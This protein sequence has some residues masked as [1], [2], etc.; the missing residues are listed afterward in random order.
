MQATAPSSSST[1]VSPISGPPVEK[2]AVTL[3]D[4][5]RGGAEHDRRS[6]QAYLHTLAAREKEKRKRKRMERKQKRSSSSSS[7]KKRRTESGAPTSELNG[8]GTDSGNGAAGDLSNSS[9]PSGSIDMTSLMRGSV[10]LSAVRMGSTGY[11]DMRG[12]I[13]MSAMSG[14]GMGGYAADHGHW[15][16]RSV[17]FG[18]LHSSAAAFDAM[19]ASLDMSAMGPGMGAHF[20]HHGSFANGRSMSISHSHHGSFVHHPMRAGSRH[21]SV[22]F[23]ADISPTS[24]FS[25]E[26]PVF[27]EPAPLASFSSVDETHQPSPP[28]QAAAAP[29]MGGQPTV[30]L[31]QAS[32]GLPHHHLPQ[33]QAVQHQPELTEMPEFDDFVS[34]AFLQAFPDD[35]ATAAPFTPSAL[36]LEPGV[37]EPTQQQP[38]PQHHQFAVPAPRSSV[39]PAHQPTFAPSSTSS[40]ASSSPS[41]HPPQPNCSCPDC[42]TASTVSSS[43]TTALLSPPSSANYDFIACASE[44]APP[45]SQLVQASLNQSFAV[46][47]DHQVENFLANFIEWSEQCAS[48]PI[49][50]MPSP[51]SSLYF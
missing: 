28:H 27:L 44:P 13:D 34:A 35:S 14:H 41:S 48:S 50:S 46:E 20:S 25:M 2:P 31:H 37:P 49:T 15:R 30:S 22:D 7:K 19:R 51:A 1:Y 42:H 4:V 43:A 12:S 38:S 16:S 21:A 23:G 9:T 26:G 6:L 32:M 8:V 17:D 39:S 29:Y 24:S 11:D 36:L 18:A 45:G 5:L 33:P 47:E 3:A 40:A 10:D